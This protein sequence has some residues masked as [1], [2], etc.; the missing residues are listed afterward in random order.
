M[1]SLLLLFIA[2]L[3]TGET[4]SSV[5]VLLAQA[6]ELNSLNDQAFVIP[7]WSEL[8][9]VLT[10]QD[11]NTR[12]VVIS[13]A[14]LGLAAGLIGSFLLLRKQSLMGDALSHATL[15][16]IAIAFIILVLLGGNGKNL[17]I[18]LLGASVLGVIG[19]LCVLVIR[20][21]SR[22]KND[23][24]M[25]IV[26]SVFFGI[27]I[28]LLGLIQYMPE[29]SAAGLENY[30]YGKT[31]SIVMQDL[32]LIV[33]ATA[34]VLFI[35]LLLQKELTLL[36]FDDGYARSQ[37]WPVILLDIMILLLV[38]GVTVIG[39]QAVGLILI[40]AFLIIPPAAARFWTE[41]LHVMLILSGFI[42]AL[43]GWFG[44]IMSALQP[45]LPAGAVIVVVAAALFIIS[46]IFGSSRGVLFREIERLR[47]NR[48]VGMQNLLRAIYE[49]LEQ[50]ASAENENQPSVPIRHRSAR[51]SELLLVR[52][53]HARTLRHL[54]GR[55]QKA[56]LIRLSVSDVCTLTEQGF[57][58]AARIA[59]NHRLWEIYLITHA[60]IAPSH[61]D[62]DADQ[63]E[64]VLPADLVR[65]LEI[66]LHEQQPDR[67]VPPSPHATS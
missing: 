18:L 52:S 23:A 6:G 47:L 27:G 49:N 37:G 45:N 55:A 10:L 3:A 67:N 17:P 5:S 60:D 53:W 46:M 36:C 13:T 62:R 31:A 19:V 59:R 22:L 28:S 38:T 43:S 15:P 20:T 35:S 2:P 40:I 8:W 12:L 33:V 16:G 32:K 61:V 57:H 24:A 41:K 64:H 25:G 21:Q 1:I 9:R 34:I 26:L 29:G 4:H 48:T 30:I 66:L 58:D 65:R 42:G 44:A 50:Q 7:S 39:L 14:I 51:I 11:Y 54:I 63:I 56:E